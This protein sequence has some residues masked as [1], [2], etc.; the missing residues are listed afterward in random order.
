MNTADYVDS[1]IEELKQQVAN[2]GIP[3]S[4][5]CWETAL[6]CIE[7]AYVYSAWGAYCTPTER[8]KRFAMCP[9]HTTIKTKCQVLKGSESTCTGCQW[10]PGGKKTRCFDCRGFV[11]WVY[12]QFGFDLYGDT[13][14]VQ[15]NHKENW[16]AKGKIGVDPIPQNVLV[17]VFIKKDNKWTHTGLYFEGATCECSSGVQYFNPMKK[18]RWTHWAVAKCF[19]K[20]LNL[21]VKEPEKEKPV[22]NETKYHTLRKGNKGDWVAILQQKLILAGYNL[23][24][25][26][27]DKDFGNETLNAVKAFQKANGLTADGVVGEKTWSKLNNVI[28]EP[29]KL[30]TV[31]IKGNTKEVAEE[32]QAKYG[33]VI[34]EE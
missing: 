14:S 32:I 7:W 25:Y 30:Y 6:L 2:G 34:T 10:Y 24:K 29:V 13:C 17:N 4:D 9:T 26:G 11:D 22:S 20:E 12:K 23:P 28:S 5:A 19:E 3:L 18:N 33:G 31:T 21:P 27:V 16:C 8:R 1:R 15:W